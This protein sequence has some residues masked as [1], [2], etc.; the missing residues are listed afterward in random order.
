[1]RHSCCVDTVSIASFLFFSSRHFGLGSKKKFT[2][3]PKKSEYFCKWIS[4][5]PICK[6]QFL[7]ARQDLFN[8]SRCFYEHDF[9]SSSGKVKRRCWEK[10]F[11]SVPSRLPRPSAR[12]RFNRYATF[13]ARDDAEQQQK[14][15]DQNIIEND[16]NG[17]GSRDTTVFFF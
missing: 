16:G 6:S 10:P 17:L 14:K 9:S 3:G 11:L 7:Q 12:H 2:C 15:S 8:S 1:M 13:L 5:S 4:F